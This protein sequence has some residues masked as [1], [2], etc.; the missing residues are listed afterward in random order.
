MSA[1][2]HVMTTTH[3]RE[4]CTACDSFTEHEVT[5]WSEALTSQR[6]EGCDFYQE[7]YIEPWRLW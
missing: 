5:A 4:F 2:T 7:F 1:A 6:C 3:I